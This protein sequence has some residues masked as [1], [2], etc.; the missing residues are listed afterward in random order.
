MFV[1]AFLQKRRMPFEPI[2]PAT[3]VFSRE[4]VGHHHENKLGSVQLNG[5]NKSVEHQHAGPD[6]CGEMSDSFP[7]A[8]AWIAS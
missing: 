1:C 7:K 4:Q 3:R 6:T 8:S 5:A 2:W